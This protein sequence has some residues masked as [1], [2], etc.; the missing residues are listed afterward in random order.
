MVRTARLLIAENAS[1]SRRSHNQANSGRHSSLAIG[2]PLQSRRITKQNVDKTSFRE[3]LSN[4]KFKISNN[5]LLEMLQTLLQY[6]KSCRI[7][8]NCQRIVR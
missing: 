6:T 7:Q 4:N 8:V 3:Q 2:L 1:R 5:T